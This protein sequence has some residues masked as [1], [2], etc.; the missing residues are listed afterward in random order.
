MGLIDGDAFVSGDILSFQQAERMRTNWI[1]SD[2]QTN[3]SNPQDGMAV[4][5]SDDDK[6]YLYSGSAYEEILQLTRS[7]DVSP[8]FAS[9]RLMDTPGVDHYLDFICNEELSANKTFHLIVNDINAELNINTK[10]ALG[11]GEVLRENL[12]TNSGFGVWSQSDASKGIATI[13]YDTG[14][15]GAGTAPSVGD[16]VVGANGA[17]CVLISYTTA[18]GTWAGGNAAGV[19][20]VGAV[21]HDFAFVDNE[22]LTFGGVETAAVN[23]PDSAVQV[24]LL[25]N[26]GFA[27]DTD[28]PPG[29]DAMDDAVLTTEGAGKVGNCLMITEGGSINPYA[30]QNPTLEVGKIYKFTCYV[31]AGTEATYRVLLSGATSYDTGSIEETAGDWSTEVQVT[32]EATTTALEIRLYNRAAAASGLTIYFDEVTL[33]E[34][35]PCCTATDTVAFDI[36]K[37]SNDVDI[38]RQHNDDG[39]YTKD[40]SFYSLKIVP[41]NATENVTFPNGY[42]DKEE[43]RKQFEGRTLAAGAWIKTSTASHVRLYIYDGALNYSSYHTGGGAWEWIEVSRVIGAS[44][45]KVQ[46]GIITNIAGN[47]DGSTIVYVS[48]PMLVFGSYIGEGNYKPIP[49]EVIWITAPIK[50]NLLIANNWSDV[51]FTAL[52][53]EADSDALLPKGAK[54]ILAYSQIQDSGSAGTN[55]AFIRL[56]AD[57]IQVK[58]YFNVCAGLPNDFYSKK[59]GWQK[60]NNNGDVDYHIEASGANTLDIVDFEYTAVQVN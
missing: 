57:S 5:D 56:R 21:S 46:C 44:P 53:L 19:L 60:C 58:Q 51:A 25:Q 33:Y 18:T 31:K 30:E 27:T 34:I 43:W 45:A 37:K 39:T 15:K 8:Q 12:L 23:M 40:G 17:T 32:F 26:G 1:Q 20:T 11:I 42:D 52:N 10:E 50:S 59:D 14:N 28:P 35:T 54:A 2:P 6:F 29:W 55:N 4:V 7:F 48:Q 38:Y 22:V 36:W 41:Q 3:I 24:G 9:V 49:Q 47:V 13:T 16:A